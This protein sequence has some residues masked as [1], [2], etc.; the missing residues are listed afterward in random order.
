MIRWCSISRLERRSSKT[1]T[2]VRPLSWF[3]ESLK[4]GSYAPHDGVVLT[5]HL[6]TGPGESFVER[7]RAAVVAALEATSW[8]DPW[9]RHL[10]SGLR[11]LDDAWDARGVDYAGMVKPA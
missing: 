7:N 8:V 2:R 1:R 10:F 11:L 5:L 6:T 4:D 9:V 3:L